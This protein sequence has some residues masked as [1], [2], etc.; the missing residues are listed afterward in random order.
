MGQYT[1]PAQANLTVGGNQYHQHPELSPR[2][3]C[4]ARSRRFFDV[5]AQQPRA[6]GGRGLRVR[7]GDVQPRSP[8]AGAPSSTITRTA[9]RRCGP[10]TSRRSRRSS[11]TGA[12]TR[13]SSRTT[14]RSKRTVGQR[15]ACCSTATSSRRTSRA[16]AAARRR[17][18]SRGAPRSTSRTATRA[19]FLRFGFGDEVQPRLGVSYQLRD[20]SGRQGRTRTGAATTTWTRSRAAAAWRRT[21]S[22]RRRPSST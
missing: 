18:R 16:A 20:A 22:S 13:S 7:R 8:T 9:C 11:A 3:S 14:S 12:P 10:A 21:A 19:R 15:R 2:T 4:A 1:D 17:C 5:G 6:E